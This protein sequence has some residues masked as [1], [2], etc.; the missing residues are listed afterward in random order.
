M[1]QIL[2]EL[3]GVV[4]FF[5]DIATQGNTPSELMRKDGK[6]PNLYE[7]SHYLGWTPH[8]FFWPI[9]ELCDSFDDG[10]TFFGAVSSFSLTLLI[11]LMLL[12]FLKD[13]YSFS[14]I[15]LDFLGNNVLSASKTPSS[16]SDGS[17]PSFFNSSFFCVHFV[18][19]LFIK[20]KNQNKIAIFVS[21]MLI[22]FEILVMALNPNLLHIM[23]LAFLLVF[24]HITSSYWYSKF[25]YYR[26]QIP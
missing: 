12:H 16:T 1:G 20:R 21:Q 5:D 25:M 24:I 3:E 13:W 15:I 6:L 7:V 4:W 9:L 8:L 23:V 26:M 11:L 10:F 19:A 17:S 18:F 2:Q 14:Y 22:S